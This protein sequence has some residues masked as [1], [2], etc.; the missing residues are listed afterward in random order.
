[1]LHTET[2]PVDVECCIDGTPLPADV[3]HA[4][5]KSE[6]DHPLA[7]PLCDDCAKPIWDLFGDGIEKAENDSDLTLAENVSFNVQNML[8]RNKNPLGLSRAM[9]VMERFGWSPR[10]CSDWVKFARSNQSN[11]LILYSLVGIRTL[12]FKS[13]SLCFSEEAVACI[14]NEENGLS[15]LCS[16]CV[17]TLV[18]MAADGWLDPLKLP[19][20]NLIMTWLGRFDPDEMNRLTCSLLVHRLKDGLACIAVI[21]GETV[22]GTLRHDE[23]GTWTCDGRPIITDSGEPCE[24]VE[25][26]NI[27]EQ[28][29]E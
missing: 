23:N 7:G 5:V 17:N 9:K 4:Y 6:G 2:L 12:A 25:T 29:D 1:M 19:P 16:D 3:P 18:R 28:W 8:S 13:C 15:P 20:L 26:L 27:I 14:A 11:G 24:G 21:H 10:T 22:S